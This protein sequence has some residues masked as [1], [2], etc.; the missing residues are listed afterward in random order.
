MYHVG[1][2]ACRRNIRL[3]YIYWRIWF[4]KYSEIFESE[5]DF[6]LKGLEYIVT[7]CLGHNEFE[8]KKYWKR[9]RKSIHTRAIERKRHSRTDI[10]RNR[11]ILENTSPGV[12]SWTCSI[13][14]WHAQTL[15]MA[16]KMD[17]CEKDKLQNGHLLGRHLLAH[18][19][20]RTNI[21]WFIRRICARAVCH[22]AESD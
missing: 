20:P 13:L 10:S 18:T 9:G 16:K 22:S 4:R 11:R 8:G 2:G 19:N 17:V 1:Q 5:S 15:C 3:L 6:A 21:N 14:E 7:L 12:G